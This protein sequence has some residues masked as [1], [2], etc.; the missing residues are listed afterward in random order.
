[1]QQHR[2]TGRHPAGSRRNLAHTATGGPVAI[3]GVERTR[4][5]GIER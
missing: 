3:R 4:P 2:R 1:M 5:L